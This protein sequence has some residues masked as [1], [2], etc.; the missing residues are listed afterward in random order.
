MADQAGVRIVVVARASG[1]LWGDSDR[2]IQTLT[3][4]LGNAIK[5]SPRGTDRDLSG[6]A[7]DADFV[8]CVADQ[9][10]GMPEEKL[11]TIFE[12]FSQ[13]DASD[14]R[15]KGGSGLGLAICQSIV[16]AHGGRIWA[17]KNDPAGSRFQFTIPL[18]VQVLIAQPATTSAAF[19]LPLPVRLVEAGEV[20]AALVARDMQEE[21]DDLRPVA[22]RG[23]VRR[24]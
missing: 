11:E 17:E 3:N 12:R 2:I 6:T 23:D 8:F 24:R 20:A 14:S 16:N 19:E 10:R 18:A 1:T 22:G 4:L 15:D 5:F 7:R 9:G 21:L 13:V